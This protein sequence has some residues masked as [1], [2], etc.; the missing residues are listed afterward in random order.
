MAPTPLPCVH[1]RVAWRG[2]LLTG[3]LLVG[4]SAVRAEKRVAVK[5]TAEDD[6]VAERYDD[7]GNRKIQKYVFLEGTFQEGAIRDRSLENA[8]IQEIARTLAPFL[9]RKDFLPTQQMQDAD[10]VIA[11]HWGTTISLRHN[12]DYVSELMYQARDRQ[13][14]DQEFYNAA[15]K[16]EE[17]ND[18]IPGDFAQELL[19]QA[20]AERAAA[21]DYDWARLA[22]TRSERDFENRPTATLL[23]FG[24]VLNRDSKRAFIGEDARTVKAMLDEERYYI[25]LAAYDLKQR[26]DRGTPQRLWVARLSTRSAGTNF[27]EAVEKLGEVGSNFFGEN[28]PELVIE[29][30]PEKKQN[31]QVEVGE[32]IVVEDPT[33]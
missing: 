25:V 2:L 15:Y 10:I 7:Q 12:R 8:E 11:I 19:Q 16:D 6:Y 14:A 4:V 29:R 26:D 1:P 22:S 3:L 32:P 30:A 5:A 13:L 31:A 9:A 21:P 17:G 24:D 18:I 28:H 20:A 27:Q 33:P 23:G